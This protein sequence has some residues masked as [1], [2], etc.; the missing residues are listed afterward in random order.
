MMR[1]DSPAEYDSALSKKLTPASRAARQA[2]RGEALVELRAEGDPRAERQ[3]AHLE[4]RSAQSAVLHLHGDA[5]FA[6]VTR[7]TKAVSLRVRR[8]DASP[9]RCRAARETTPAPELGARGQGR[10]APTSPLFQMGWIWT[11]CP[12][13]GG[14]DDVAPTDVHPDVRDA[15]AAAPEHEVARLHRRQRDVGDGAV[16]RGGG[17]GKADARPVPRPTG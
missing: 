6:S 3:H 15:P 8:V 1:S 12:V 14:V 2:V 17:A 10:P 4:A 13:V 11:S 16:L 9:R 7:P 5:P